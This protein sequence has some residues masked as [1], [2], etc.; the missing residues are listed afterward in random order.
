ME[1]LVTQLVERKRNVRNSFTS[2]TSQ[3]INGIMGGRK[4]L[5]EKHFRFPI[6]RPGIACHEN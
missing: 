5:A 3:W 6:D 4:V 2:P 1:P